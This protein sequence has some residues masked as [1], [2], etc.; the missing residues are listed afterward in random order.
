[1]VDGLGINGIITFCA[2]VHYGYMA[3]IAHGQL[4]RWLG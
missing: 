3:H 1:M 2:R 4:I